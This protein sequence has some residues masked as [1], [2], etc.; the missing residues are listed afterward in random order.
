MLE[1][2]YHLQCIRLEIGPDLRLL[3]RYLAAPRTQSTIERLA[4]AWGDIWLYLS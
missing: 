1:C 4:G 3:P 2:M